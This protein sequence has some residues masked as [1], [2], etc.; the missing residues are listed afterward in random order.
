MMTTSPHAVE[1]LKERM[2]PGVNHRRLR[3][4]GFAARQQPLG[5]W[6]MLGL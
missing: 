2:G 3:T 5:P 1:W 4:E 6:L